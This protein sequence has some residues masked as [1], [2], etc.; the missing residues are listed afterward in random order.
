MKLLIDKELVDTLISLHSNGMLGI[1]DQLRQLPEAKM[2]DLGGVP[3]H[4]YRME[5]DDFSRIHEFVEVADLTNA[6]LPSIGRDELVD[7]VQKWL[8]VWPAYAD[9]LA[10]AILDRIKGVK[11]G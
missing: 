8:R 2:L 4:Y 3:K 1:A 10:D 9:D 11:H 5:A 7:I 6:V